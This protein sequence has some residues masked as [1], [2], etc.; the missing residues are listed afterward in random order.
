MK[1]RPFHD[2]IAVERI[3]SDNAY[4]RRLVPCPLFPRKQQTE[5]VT[6]FDLAGECKERRGERIAKHASVPRP[7]LRT[8]SRRLARRKLRRQHAAALKGIEK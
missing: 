7:R 1:F 6:F 3:T 5:I 4:S 2:R 8:Y